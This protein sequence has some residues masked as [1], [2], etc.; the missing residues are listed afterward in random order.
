MTAP[1]TAD[2]S[3]PA[4]TDIKP[5]S[6]VKLSASQVSA[7]LVEARSLIAAGRYD[8]ADLIVHP[9]LG[10]AFL[11]PQVK[12]LRDQLVQVEKRNAYLLNLLGR[13]SANGEW[14][15]ML[16]TI[17]AIEKLH[18][19][20]TNQVKL[21]DFAKRRLA[22]ARAKTPAGNASTSGG[23]GTSHTNSNQTVRPPATQTASPTTTAPP[24][25]DNGPTGPP[26]TPTAADP[27]AGGGGN[28][29]GN[30]NM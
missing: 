4:T 19:L 15:S 10:Q 24:K 28:V 7:K 23:G 22:A 29:M 8:E 20:F 2:L 11:A 5:A 3:L 30:M 9:L 18:P 16:T 27:T 17:A 13:Q 1:P 12:A 6:K 26:P 14:A 25:T 21:R